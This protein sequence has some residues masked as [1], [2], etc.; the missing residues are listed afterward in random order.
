MP[1]DA[2]SYTP[3]EFRYIVFQPFRGEILQGT[4]A[5][6]SNEGIR[7]SMLFFSDIFVT[8]DRMPQVSK[9]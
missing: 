7:I 5:S 6:C 1:G 8:P 9:L 4:I 2:N 3:V